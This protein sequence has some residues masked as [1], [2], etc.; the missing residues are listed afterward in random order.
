MLMELAHQLL[1]KLKITLLFKLIILITLVFYVLYHFNHKE[2]LSHYKGNEITFK[3]V[4]KNIKKTDN[5][6]TLIIKD[7]ENLLVNYYTDKQ[8]DYKLGDTVVINGTLSSPSQ[9]RNFHLFNYRNYLLSKKI[10]YIV[11]TKTITKYKDNKN[12][13]YSIKQKLIDRVD[14]T[15]NAY[16]KALILG[17]NSNIDNDKLTSYQNNGISHLLAIS[18]MHVTILSSIILKVLNKLNKKKTINEIIIIIFL[19]FYAFLVSFSVSII[20]ASLM[21]IISRVFKIFKK[22][23][24]PVEIFLITLVITLFINPFY[25]YSVS[26]KYSYTI[27][28]YLIIFSN[29]INKRKHYLTKIFITSLIAFLVS[30]PVQINNFYMVNFLSIFLNVIFVPIFSLIIFPLAIFTFIFPCFINIFS[31]LTNIFENISLF[32]NQFTFLTFNFSYINAFFYIY[33]YIII[34]LLLLK[35]RGSFIIILILS[36]IIH[37][38]INYFKNYSKIIMLDVGQGD[39]IL[40]SLEHNK[41]NILIDTGGIINYKGESSYSV[42]EKTIIPYLKSIGI[43]KLD[44]LILT[45]GD[46][47]HAGDASFLINNFKVDNVV[48][49]IGKYNEVELNLIELLEKKNI[50]YYKGLE[51]LNIDNYKFSFLNTFIY[52]NENDN[53]NVIYFNYNSFKFL[54]MGDSE[55]NREKD[56]LENYNLVDIDFLKVGH[57]GSNTSSSREFINAINPKYSLI[58]VGKNNRY[59]HPK[60]SVLDTLSNSKVYRTDIDGSIEIKLSKSWYRIRTCLP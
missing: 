47:D 52:D 21:L 59:G 55:K 27:C 43:K 42:S 44:Y 53:S 37:Y 15:H 6:I 58:S 36:F 48:F 4:I 41:G 23:I 54:F 31:V 20:R 24:K 1:K 29:L 26:F 34:T 16:L 32:F 45:H 7:K 19:I 10:Y 51:E 17:D 46:Y 56:I 30:I 12:L 8:F 5:K 57:H 25:L 14:K 28:F 39:S 11:N 60:E 33:Y 13:L 9:N 3:G 22:K 40:I 2:Q 35:T 38:N 49:N 50:R 18:G